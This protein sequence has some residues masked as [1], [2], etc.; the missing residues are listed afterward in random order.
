M[1][2]RPAGCSII[3]AATSHDA[4]IPYCGDVDV[5][6]MKASLNLAISS[7]LF[8]ACWILFEYL[9]LELSPAFP[10]D[11]LITLEVTRSV[12]RDSHCFSTRHSFQED[13][14]LRVA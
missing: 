7:R 2:A 5:C 13:T 4:M 10:D 6:I 11:S 1:S 3:A 12:D 14:A 9:R 8:S